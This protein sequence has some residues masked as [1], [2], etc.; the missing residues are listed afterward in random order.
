MADKE[1]IDPPANVPAHVVYFTVVIVGGFLL[2]LA[3]LLAV[4]R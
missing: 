3:V 1:P 2:N 4:A